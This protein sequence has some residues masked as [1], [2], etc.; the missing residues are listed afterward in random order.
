MA[1]RGG[2]GYGE[3]IRGIPGC[4]RTPAQPGKAISVDLGGVIV[5]A[6]YSTLRPYWWWRSA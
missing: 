5:Q 6:F 3:N 4:E 2:F 1:D